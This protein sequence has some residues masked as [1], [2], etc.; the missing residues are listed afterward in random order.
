MNL[1]K[2]ALQK[3]INEIVNRLIP[4]EAWKSTVAI[5][6]VS[7][8]TLRP[9]A[10]GTLLRVADEYFLLTAGHVINEALKYDIGLCITGSNNSFVQVPIPSNFER[11]HGELPLKMIEYES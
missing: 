7:G 1:D 3:K 2:E 6:S 8:K 10:T 9:F 4:E 11:T 5:I